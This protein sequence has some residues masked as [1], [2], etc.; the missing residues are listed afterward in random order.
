MNSPSISAAVPEID[1]ADRLVRRVAGFQAYLREHGFQSGIPESRDALVLARAVDLTDRYRLRSGLKCL[2]CSGQG[3]WS[4]FDE[5]FDAYWLPPNR[6]VLRE[7]RATAGAAKPES[8]LATTPPKGLLTDVQQG[9]GD[10]GNVAGDDAAQG[11]AAS[12]E[13]PERKDFRHLAG[14]ELDQ[15][16]RLVD[17]LASRMRRRMVRRQRIAAAGRK[18][19]LRRTLRN[20]L[21]FGGIPMELSYRARR[22]KPPQLVILL[23][24]S[25]SMSI[26]TYLL[27][28]FTRAIIRAFRRADAFVFHTRLVS[29]TDALKEQNAERMR[30][31]LTLLSAGWSGGTRIG[32]SLQS[33]ND[34]FAGSLVGRR[35][36]VVVVSDGFDTGDPSLLSAQMERLHARARRVVWLNPLLGRLNYE[37]LASGMAAAMPFVDL[38]A[39][40]HNVESL[41]ALEHEL[42]RL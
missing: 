15:V 10:A 6:S 36:V 42:V 29:V 25:R 12:T 4:R 35:T 19:H 1:A 28:R 5:L 26:Y 38:F 27:L 8:D 30:D 20:S 24:V 34:R 3:E 7:N 17:R 40:A 13:S 39:P 41:L 22:R 9:A 33:F 2:L 18:L 16:E 11:G 14:D 31:R 37:P 32:E 23:D 21:Q